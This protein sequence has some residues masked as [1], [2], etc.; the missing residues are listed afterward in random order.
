M[1]KKQSKK[2]IRLTIEETLRNWDKEVVLSGDRYTKPYQ[3][4]SNLCSRVLKVGVTKRFQ[5]FV[6]I[7]AFCSW[8]HDV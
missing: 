7:G 1:N 2:K 8:T 4:S 5:A 3:V 6:R